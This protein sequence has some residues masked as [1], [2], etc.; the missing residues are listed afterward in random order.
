MTLK[1]VK[2]FPLSLRVVQVFSAFLVLGNVIKHYVLFFIYYEKTL[3]SILYKVSVLEDW[4][5]NLLPVPLV[6]L[7]RFYRGACM[8]MADN[9]L[10]FFFTV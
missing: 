9:G 6:Q 10:I 4:S 3:P 8:T 2:R 5:V 1:F 7:F